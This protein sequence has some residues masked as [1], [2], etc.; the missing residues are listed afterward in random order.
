MNE[1]GER[2]LHLLG[3]LERELDR[4]GSP[5]SSIAAPPV[6]PW[7]LDEAEAR[8]GF[9][10]PDE[11]R[12]WWLWHDGATRVPGHLSDHLL[13]VG[14]LEAYPLAKALHEWDDWSKESIF[15]EQ[16]V[17]EWKFLESWVPFAGADGYRRLN[18]K[19]ELSG[20]DQ[21]VLGVVEVPWDG[22]EFGQTVDMTFPELISAWIEYLQAG[23]ARWSVEE[24]YWMREA[25]PGPA[26]FDRY[27]FWG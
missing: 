8:V 27:L 5:F 13:G 22:I 4:Q 9:P 12:A 11:L 1:A 19:L 18:A 10:F 17:S 23:R 24:G 16:S 6:E 21:L 14:G 7:Q 3:E 20:P 15:R 25:L 26:T 2:V